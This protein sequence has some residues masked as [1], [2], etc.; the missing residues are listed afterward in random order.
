M[1]STQPIYYC[2]NCHLEIPRI[3][4]T[5]NPTCPQ[6]YDQV[7]DLCLKEQWWTVKVD[8]LF[9]YYYC[10]IFICSEPTQFVEEVCCL[11]TSF[12]I[13]IEKNSPTRYHKLQNVKFGYFRA[14]WQLSDVSRRHTDSNLS[15]PQID[16]RTPP[17]SITIMSA[18]DIFPALMRAVILET[19]N[20]RRRESRSINMQVIRR[21]SDGSPIILT[22]NFG[23]VRTAL[24]GDTRSLQS[25]NL[26][27]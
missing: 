4:R 3:L 17:D 16:H 1:S 25:M 18:N 10:H 26:F 2:H 19:E 5:P 11:S 8:W 22:N 6:C 20:Q 12:N 13:L 23:T 9:F 15:P 21:G 24:Y 7:M 14:S 27:G